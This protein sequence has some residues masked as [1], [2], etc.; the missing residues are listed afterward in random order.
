MSLHVQ[1]KLLMAVEEKRIYP[2]GSTKLLEID[3]RIIA[4]TNSN[5]KQ[6]V[7]EKRFR[8]DLFFR[9]C[10]FVIALPPLRERVDD[11]PFFAQRF[12]IEVC[13]HLSTYTLTNMGCVP[14]F[15]SI[16][17][18][19]I[20]LYEPSAGSAM[21]LIIFPATRYITISAIFVAWSAIL[22]RY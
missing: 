3:V 10:E 4:A 18:F 20:P 17:P 16:T 15:G 7:K 2:L 12:F 8:E 9:L 21:C 6:A 1:G 11:I 5:I 22:S 13:I 19:L 14:N